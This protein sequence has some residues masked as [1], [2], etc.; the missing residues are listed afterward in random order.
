ML[1]LALAS[2]S[3]AAPAAVVDAPAELGVGERIPLAVRI[4]GD[5]RPVPPP[6]RPGAGLAGGSTGWSVTASMVGGVV[7]RRV[8]CRYCVEGREGGGWEVTGDPVPVATGAVAI[9]PVTITVVAKPEHPRQLCEMPAAI[10]PH[11]P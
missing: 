10:P 11:V 3:L 5:A 9:R 2:T 8:E 6:L 1:Q 7:S 4:E